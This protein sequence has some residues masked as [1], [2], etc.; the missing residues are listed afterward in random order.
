MMEVDDDEDGDVKGEGT[1]KD[2]KEEQKEEGEKETE[3]P[4]E[5][6]A[7]EDEVDPL[8]AYMEEVKQEVKKFNIGAMKGNDKV[9]IKTTHGITLKPL[10]SSIKTFLFSL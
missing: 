4:M 10:S 5:Q 1:A 9:R 7:E 2:I 8:D 6:P 3:T